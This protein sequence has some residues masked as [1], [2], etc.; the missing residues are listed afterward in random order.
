M[1]TQKVGYARVSTKEQDLSLQLDAL[2]KFDCDKVFTDKVSSAKQRQGLQ[3]ALNYLRS[4]DC[5]VVWKLDRLCRSLPDLIKISQQLK[6]KG[7]ELISITE[8]IDTS[9]PAGRLYFN[10]L[11]ALGQ[12]ER[13]LIQERVKAGLMAAKKRG[14]VGGKPRVNQDKIDLARRE[15]SEGRTYPDVARIIGIHVQTLYRL[16][17][18]MSLDARSNFN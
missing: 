6:D 5:L 3:D 1:T 16:V 17:P 10:I 12:M 11:G 13:E 7:C 2:N 14:R 15:L 18:V 8:N 9:T 4:G